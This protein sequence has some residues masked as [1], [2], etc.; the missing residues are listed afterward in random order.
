MLLNLAKKIHR[1][2]CI[3]IHIAIGENVQL[4]NTNIYYCFLE[5][6]NKMLQPLKRFDWSNGLDKCQIVFN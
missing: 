6:K 1:I 5:G 2:I 3:G 4:L